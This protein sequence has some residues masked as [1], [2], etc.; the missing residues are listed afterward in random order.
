MP[1]EM[2]AESEQP[3]ARFILH[4]SSFI[5]CS[6]AFTLVELLVV[7]GILGVL[8]AILIPAV[9]AAQRQA[10]LAM[11][12]SNVRQMT[13]AALMHAQ[14]HRG[15]LPLAGELVA[16]PNYSAG[17]ERYSDPLR[18]SARRKYTYAGCPN[19]GN[20]YVPVPLPGALAPYMGLSDLP[21]EDWHQ[22]DQILNRTE[23]VKRFACPA[24]DAMW[25]ERKYEDA[26]N[27]TLARQG[28]MMALASPLTGPVLAWSSNSDYA[29]NEGVFGYHENPIYGSRRLGGNIIKLRGLDR[30]VLFSDAKIRDTLAYPWMKDPWICW[31]PALSSKGAVTLADALSNNGKA[32]DRSMFDL[33]R[34]KGR[35][36]VGFA[37]GHVD[38]KRIT[39]GDLRNAY[40]LV[41]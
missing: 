37:D 5:V 7:I 21:Y 3:R 12:A 2:K 41:R 39:A 26:N 18:D 36:N 32:V 24:S 13:M 15:Y 25:R 9:S 16:T 38:L 40:L 17:G 27:L 10:S 11:C 14:D 31:T 34:H 20:F 19:L 35:M 30:L 29:F 1:A 22:F 6:S 23:F 33:N 4:P 8:I 28:T